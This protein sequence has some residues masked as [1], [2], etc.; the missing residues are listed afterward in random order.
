MCNVHLRDSSVEIPLYRREDICSV[1]VFLSS[2]RNNG[3]LLFSC[4]NATVL[5]DA[6]KE[7][8]EDRNKETSSSSEDEE[9]MLYMCVYVIEKEV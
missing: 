2:G 1:F 3:F 6:L 9:D 5:S 4:S 8:D 7:L